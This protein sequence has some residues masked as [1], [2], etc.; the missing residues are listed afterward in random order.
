MERNAHARAS[1]ASSPAAGATL[2]LPVATTSSTPNRMAASAGRLVGAPAP[3]DPSGSLPPADNG[4]HAFQKYVEGIYRD[5]P[6]NVERC[7]VKAR[8]LASGEGINYAPRGAKRYDRFM[9]GENVNFWTCD[10]EEMKRRAQVWLP[11]DGPKST[12]ADKTN[13]WVWK[14][15]LERIH[16]FQLCH[17]PSS[18]SAAS[19]SA[20][21]LSQ[22]RQEDLSGL[23]VYY[24][25]ELDET[26]VD[27]DVLCGMTR[28]RDTA[29]AHGA[30]QTPSAPPNRW[31]P[32]G[33]NVQR[34]RTLGGNQELITYLRNG[35]GQPQ[36][37]KRR[38][39][40]YVRKSGESL[41]KMV[42]AWL[43]TPDGIELLRGCDVC[44]DAATIDHV[45]PES[46]GGPDHLWNYH[47]MPRSAN[48]HFK[49]RPWTDAE[50]QQYVGASQVHFV[51][52][53]L[54]EAREVLDWGAIAPDS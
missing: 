26:H 52:K 39:V 43:K 2:A 35:A 3:F 1:P 34:L 17:K 16:Q 45:M 18:S 4:L 6:G 22:Q 41:H 19:Y 13:G 47:I 23:A 28:A 30:G 51:R 14:H 12:W 33:P 29:E 25:R 8:A 46:L 42:T 24:T 27:A 21:S 40:D 5:R 50:K 49:E 11:C 9:K 53:L 44:P 48:S 20:A 15:P 32:P 7:M 36:N 10:V 38:R 31:E 54:S 37:K